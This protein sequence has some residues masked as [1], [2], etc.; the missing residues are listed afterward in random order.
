MNLE[1]SMINLTRKNL[2]NGQKG[3][4]MTKKPSDKKLL[5]IT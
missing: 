5:K 2:D 1:L 3:P 4:K